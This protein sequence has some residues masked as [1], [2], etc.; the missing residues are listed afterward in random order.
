[1]MSQDVVD[2]LLALDRAGAQLARLVGV[3]EARVVELERRLASVS[4]AEGAPP[5]DQ[6][7]GVR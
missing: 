4:H 6:S 5:A 2:A 7:S 3:L 1:M